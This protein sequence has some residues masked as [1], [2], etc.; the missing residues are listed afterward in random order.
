MKAADVFVCSSRAEGYSLVIAEAM[1][2][3]KPVL[4]VDCAG[5]N[6]IL[7]FGEFGKLVPNTD[8][9][10]YQMLNELLNGNIDLENYARLSIVRQSFFELP[11]IIEK[12]ETLFLT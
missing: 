7:N 1:I 2:L 6:E 10:L 9:N 5:P 11:N 3:G 12:V 4:S 8:E